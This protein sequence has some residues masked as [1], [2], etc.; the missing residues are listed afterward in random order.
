MVHRSYRFGAFRLECGPVLLCDD[1]PVALGQRAL[2]LLALLIEHRGETVSKADIFASVWPGLSVSDANLTSQIWALRQALGDTKRPFRWI[3]SVSARGYRFIGPV[4]NGTEIALSAAAESRPGVPRP[5]TRLFGR[6][7]DLITVRNALNRAG[8]VTLVGPG[9]IGKTRLALELA[10]AAQ[11]DFPDGTVFVD[12]SVVRDSALAPQRIATALGID[13]K[14][15]LPPGEQIARRLKPR[16]VLII[17]DNCE[18]VLESVAPLAEA[19]IQ[20]HSPARLLATSREALACSGE[21]V[22]RLPLLPVPSATVTSAAEAL[23]AASVALLVDRAQAADLHFALTD[24]LAEPAAA[25]CRRL[26]GLPLA[27]EMVG[28][29][30]PSFGLKA[31]ERHLVKAS[32]LPHGGSATA[33]PRHRSLDTLLD[34]S[35][36]LLSAEERTLLYRL[37]I[38]PAYFTLDAVAAVMAEHAEDVAE[39]AD[40]LTA[41][42]RKSLVT[43]DSTVEP[44][45]YR[46]LETIRTYA[47]QKLTAAGELDVM[48][49]RHARYLGQHLMHVWRVW[50]TASDQ[51]FS[52]RYAPLV[53]DM[54]RALDWSLKT[55]A[56]IPLGLIIIGQSWPIWPITNLVPEGR[57][58][59]EEAV[60]V[61][62]AG[63]PD[64]IAAPVWF[65]LGSLTGERSF[66]RSTEA[67]RRAADGFQRLGETSLLGLTL[68]GLGQVL[69]L[70]GRPTDAREAL[71]AA[72]VALSSS[73][74]GRIYGTLAISLGMVHSGT[75]AWSGSRREYQRAADILQHIGAD[76]MATAALYNLAD[77]IWVEG[78]LDE[79]IEAMRA[80][81]DHTRRCGNVRFL[82]AAIGGL[83]GML[84]ARGD[85]DE[86]LDAARD[87]YPLC[88]DDEYVDWL[89]DHLALRL[90]KLGHDQDA[91]RLWGYAERT[92]AERQPNEQNAIR[93]L[94]ALLT[95]HLTA[96]QLATLKARG[97]LLSDEQA[98]ALAFI[99]GAPV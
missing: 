59:A 17:L 40:G 4:N 53:E 82:G 28:A 63:T 80:A 6:A 39:A 55:E 94:E 65:T 52:D 98:V 10:R 33:S 12:L 19:V 74:K 23:S 67:L 45:R 51:A 25:I 90:A 69:A 44:A 99:S 57:R 54:R 92:G 29:L 18:H 86:A 42:V 75:G 70:S 30:A 32:R 34:W 60:A 96:D 43:F 15:D 79:A 13:I 7:D 77:A 21:Q 38:F 73:V 72:S 9:G 62:P 3:V 14:G 47:R 22:Y 2:A 81:I 68:A 37:G 16:A 27:L 66:E 61:M 1:Q 78:M 88:R 95:P 5:L 20:E 24:E 64:E 91:A 93:A 49:L 46:L 71:D 26:D 36:A 84:I 83:A 11:D 8:M 48:R 76:R 35:V 41:L 89:F 56:A 58:W 97:R 50:D 87:A 85:L 31:I